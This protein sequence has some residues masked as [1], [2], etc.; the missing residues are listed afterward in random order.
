MK[1][2]LGSY[3][4]VYGA[5]V[6]PVFAILP[7]VLAVYIGVTTEISG[8]AVFLIC[9]CCACSVIWSVYVKKEAL[10]FY[11]WG[12][13]EQ[14]CVRIRGL[15]VPE[16][17]LEYKMCKDVGVGSYT[18]GILN[19]SV[20]SKIYFI[21]L[22]YEQFDEKYRHHINLWKPNTKRIKIQFS[23]E[24]LSY[25]CACLP[26]NQAKMLE[27]SYEKHFFAKK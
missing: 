24:A 17:I 26:K 23:Q 14:D 10:Q 13:F 19:T 9:L 7:L 16:F 3:M 1:K 5:V 21:Y 15:F 12:T 6:A 11:A 8:A 2:Y 20:G 25:L 18:H 27:N 22:S 4:N